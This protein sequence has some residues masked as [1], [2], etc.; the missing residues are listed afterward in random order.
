MPAVVQQA[1]R[2][3]SDLDDHQRLYSKGARA[4]RRDDIL[5]TTENDNA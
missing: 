5:A 1:G 3:I 2:T 4:G